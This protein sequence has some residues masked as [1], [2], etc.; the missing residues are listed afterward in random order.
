[1]RRRE[2]IF[3][4]GTAAAAWPSAVQA[5]QA[6]KIA[7]LVFLGATTASNI[8]RRLEVFRS[9]LRNLGY[10]E[11]QNMLIDFRWAGGQ[12][13]QLPA[14]AVELVR[15]NVDVL[16]TYGTPGTL[17]AKQ[18]TMTVPI[19]MAGCGDAVAVGIVAGLARPGGNVTGSTFFTPEVSAKQIEL[20]KEAF[21]G[22]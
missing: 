21:P 3:L 19:V 17:A 7:H 4:C 15:L 22:T 11:G 18:I 8:A 9:E 16:V 6:G 1:M 20:L 5:Q 12:Y 2:F 13:D 10:V 14:L